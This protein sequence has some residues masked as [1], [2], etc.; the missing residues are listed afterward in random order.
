MGNKPGRNEDLNNLTATNNIHKVENEGSNNL[1]KSSTPTITRKAKK[2]KE[3]KPG[4]Q[5]ADWLTL[6]E[7]P[8]FARLTSPREVTR[9][10]LSKHITEN[11]CWTILHG[12]VYDITAYLEYHPGGKRELMKGAGKDCTALFNKFHAYVEYELLLS[13]CEIGILVEGGDE[14]IEE[15]DEDEED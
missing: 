10:E 12:K 6:V 3:G 1:E 15:G 13:K 14:A 4:F 2:K 7:S 5:L 11:D 8:D 9:N